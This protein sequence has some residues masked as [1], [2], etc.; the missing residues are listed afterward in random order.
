LKCSNSQAVKD[1]RGRLGR[2][3]G[4]FECVH[5]QLRCAL[6]GAFAVK[7]GDRVSLFYPVAGLRQYLYSGAV[8][9][10][11]ALLHPS[12]P[13]REGGANKALKIR[14]VSVDEAVKIFR[15]A[16]YGEAF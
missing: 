6:R 10:A 9:Y 7:T 3:A 8:V 1:S 4:E 15:K 5:H 14:G 11:V 2:L 13:Q 16:A 12:G